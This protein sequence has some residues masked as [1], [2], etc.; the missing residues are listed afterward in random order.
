MKFT[1]TQ[2]DFLTVIASASAVTE[3]K[4]NIPILT[5]LLLRAEGDKLVV[6]GTDLDT[7][8][9]N[10]VKAQVSKSGSICLNA[11]KLLGI[12]KLL[13]KDDVTVTVDGSK[14]TITCGGSKFKLPGFLEK[15][16]PTI[17]EATTPLCTLPHSFIEILSII[18]ASATKEESR[19]ALNGA[20]LEVKDGVTSL[21]STDGHR[22][23]H[24]KTEVTTPTAFQ[25]I[26]SKKA[27]E[28]LLRMAT[29]DV[30]VF[31]APDHLK[32]KTGNTSLT[33]RLIAGQFPQY[34]TILPA[35][36]TA[37]ITADRTS[38]LAA[39]KKAAIMADERSRA[40]DIA[41]EQNIATISSQASDVG[42]AKIECPVVYNGTPLQGRF[43][44]AYWIDYLSME[45]VETVAIKTSSPV[46]QWEINPLNA[47]HATRFI[48]MPMAA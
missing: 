37:S 13:P 7:T 1:I 21:T 40:I 33:T 29:G 27:L 2:K 45:S 22:L 23:T 11:E 19:Y 10:S 5:F 18:L 3:K 12:A 26:I 35:A 38:L 17:N 25:G 48:I 30:E 32:F 15:S 9:T 24:V 36:H 34:E 8:L 14:A 43:N 44:A 39:I 47:P 28:A 4:H 6:T 20:K 31:T 16:F 42:D 41:F 46:Q